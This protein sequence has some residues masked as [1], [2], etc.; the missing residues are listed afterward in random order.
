MFIIEY[1]TPALS[2]DGDLDLELNSGLEVITFD[3]TTNGLILI[4]GTSPLATGG[5]LDIADLAMRPGQPMVVEAFSIAT[6]AGA[7]VTGTVAIRTP[8]EPGNTNNANRDTATLFNFT[9]SSAISELPILVPALHRLAF[10]IPANG[11]IRII[12]QCREL[13]SGEFQ[14]GW[15]EQQLVN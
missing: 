1:T 13:Q 4:E 10:N 8:L 15:V 6:T 3:R 12:L 7:G 11:P 2:L 9:A 5:Q 14:N